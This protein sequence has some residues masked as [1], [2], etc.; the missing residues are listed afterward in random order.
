M[1]L[2]KEQKEAVSYI[3]GQAIEDTKIKILKEIG[4]LEA[5]WKAKKLIKYDMAM[6]PKEEKQI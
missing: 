1:I 6:W 2:S 4:A 3:I 5:E